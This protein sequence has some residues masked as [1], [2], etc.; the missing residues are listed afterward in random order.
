MALLCIFLTFIITF[1]MLW[2]SIRCLLYVMSVLKSCHLLYVMDVSKMIFIRY[3]CLK[4]NIFANV[5]CT[6][7]M[8]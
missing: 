8:S 4:D 6:L 5:V 7:W 2:M 1:C 3:G